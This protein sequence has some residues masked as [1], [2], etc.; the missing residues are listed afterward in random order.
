VMMDEARKERSRE[1]TNE[2]AAQSGPVMLLGPNTTK[3]ERD[4][5]HSITRR[6]C[7]IAC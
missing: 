4:Y 6:D 7:R 3:R 2:R 5:R 1:S